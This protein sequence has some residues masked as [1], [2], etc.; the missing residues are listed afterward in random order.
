MIEHSVL[1]HTHNHAPFVTECVDSV[2]GQTR[3]PDEIIVYDAGSNDGT[4][5][6]LRQYGDRIRLIAGERDR[7]PAHLVEAHAVRTSFAASHGELLFLLDGDDR[8]KPEKIERYAAAYEN[9]PDA[10]V[11]QAPL[12]RLDHRGRS[13]GV[14]VEPRYHVTNHLREIYRRH[15]L[16]FFYP[17]SALAFSRN[18]LERVLPLQLLDVVPLWADARLCIPAAYFGRIVTLPDPWTD[19]RIH[20]PADS[21][22][23]SSGVLQVQQ[24]LRRAKVFN[25]FCRHHKLRTISPW[26]NHRLYL[27][28]LRCALPASVHDFFTRRIRPLF[29]GLS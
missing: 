27:Q 15:D 10:S 17:T 1:I 11:V 22:R 9:H 8:F 23:M 21:R 2:L 3:V 4:V 26:R 28:I 5:A 29:D 13:L 14:M 24:S 7:R 19:W 20:T 12:E 6:L 16:N 18:Y 25:D